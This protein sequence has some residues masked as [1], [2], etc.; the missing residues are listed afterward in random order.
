[1]SFQEDFDDEP[2][3]QHSAVDV[4]MEPL[5]P[6]ES[7]MPPPDSVEA[8]QRE[9]NERLSLKMKQIAGE[10]MKLNRAVQSIDRLVL[11]GV[12]VCVCVLMHPL[13]Q[14]ERDTDVTLH[15]ITE[16]TEDARIAWSLLDDRLRQLRELRTVPC[17]YL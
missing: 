15:S 13:V 6:P 12:C 7:P 5:E 3:W 9:G 8:R 17:T 4:H 11:N 2:H 16:H 10:L 1:M 14:L